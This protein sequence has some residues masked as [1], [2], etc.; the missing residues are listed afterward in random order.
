[1]SLPKL[2]SQEEVCEYLSVSIDTLNRWRCN[3]DGP[4]WVKV[5]GRVAY[6][7]NSII[8]YLNSQLNGTAEQKMRLAITAGNVEARAARKERNQQ[9]TDLDA[10]D[11]VPDA[12]KV[13]DPY[14]VTMGL[15]GQAPGSSIQRF[16]SV[17]GMQTFDN[18]PKGVAV[19]DAV[20]GRVPMPGQ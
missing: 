4:A 15:V 19:A 5:G 10:A 12:E 3:L 18:R 16:S 6:P 11:H 9:L 17:P 8:D 20:V 14:A 13:A 7:E 1:M 2:M